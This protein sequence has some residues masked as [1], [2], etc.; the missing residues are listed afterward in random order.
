MPDA[1]LDELF[2]MFIDDEHV[3]H[4][5]PYLHVH[6]FYM[7]P[8]HRVSYGNRTYTVV[9]QFL[10]GPFSPVFTA[11]N[12]VCASHQAARRPEGLPP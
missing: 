6:L 7:F 10:L 8:A 5:V 9:G 1:V 2:L 3:V 12:Q 11:Y 4:F